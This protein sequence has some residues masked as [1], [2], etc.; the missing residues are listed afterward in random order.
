[1]RLFFN[2]GQVIETFRSSANPSKA[3]I[4]QVGLDLAI[5]KVSP[6]LYYMHHRQIPDKF[7]PY[8]VPRILQLDQGHWLHIFPEAKVNQNPQY[9]LIRFRWGVSRILMETKRK[10]IEVIPVWIEGVC[11][12][13]NPLY[14]VIFVGSLTDILL[15][16]LQASMISCH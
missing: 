4:Y 7:I 10:N 5:K 3:G 2:R 16:N 1:M 9:E 8:T 11:G 13:N 14:K 6:S 15:M 12:L